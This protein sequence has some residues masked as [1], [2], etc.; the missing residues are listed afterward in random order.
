LHDL[1]CFPLRAVFLGEEEGNSPNEDGSSDIKN[2]AN[3]GRGI[4]SDGDSTCIE[5]GNSTHG[6]EYD[7]T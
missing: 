4:F 2:G 1:E 3:K 6:G 7:K 5:D